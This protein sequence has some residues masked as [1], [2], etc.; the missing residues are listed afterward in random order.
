VRTATIRLIGLIAAAGAVAASPMVVRSAEW[1]MD[2]ALR[3]QISYDDNIGLRTNSNDRVSEFGETSTID[4]SVGG[5][6]PTAEI[7][8][9]SVFD[10]TRFPDERS[11]N[12][13]D[14]YLTLSA[15]KRGQRWTARMAGSFIRDTTRTSDVE[16]TGQFILQNRR[17]EV[18]RV[19]PEVTYQLTP[20]DQVG[21]SGL[22]SDTHYPSNNLRNFQQWGGTGNWSHSLTERTQLLLIAAGFK[23][24]SGSRGSQNSRYYIAQVGAAHMF[25]DQLAARLTAGPT[26]ADT[27]VVNVSGGTRTSSSDVNFGYGFDGSIDYQFQQR[28]LFSGS[29]FR[30]VTPS[31]TTGNIVEETGFR[32]NSTYDLFKNVYFETEALY[33]FR[34]HVGQNTNTPR[35]DFVSFQPGLRWNFLD[36]WNMRLAYRFRWQRFDRDDNDEA[37][38]NSVLASVTYGI[39][40]LTMSR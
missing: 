16:D 12:S 21:F 1:Y 25:T 14:Q 36:D 2:G 17:R 7:D 18:W 27:D 26:L 34:E 19:G 9:N 11:L 6:S 37:F 23:N 22:Y 40:P 31:G 8:F 5:R 29:V 15:L 38:S 10:F 3:Q 4:M 33:K 30:T 35:R 13:N 32:F 39:P 28:L 20:V 24:N